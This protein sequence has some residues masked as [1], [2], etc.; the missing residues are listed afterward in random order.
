M[1]TP[2]HCLS[3]GFEASILLTQ[4]Q[5]DKAARIE[6]VTRCFVCSSQLYKD[7]RPYDVKLTYFK[8]T[9]KWYADNMI[10][11]MDVRP[12]QICADVRELRNLGRLPGL[13]E[14]ARDFH[15]LVDVPLHP[16]NVPTLL[17]LE[18]S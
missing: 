14:G 8:P 1:K 13:V 4:E 11:T 6:P 15:I 3:C 2:L 18:T 12:W 7:N 10:R 9:G 5:M 17:P 16:H